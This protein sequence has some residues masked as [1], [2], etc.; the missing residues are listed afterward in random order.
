MVQMLPCLVSELYFSKVCYN[1]NSLILS[2]PSVSQ[3]SLYYFMSLVHK[4]LSSLVYTLNAFKSE[5]KFFTSPGAQHC[6]E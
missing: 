1:G 2:L 5:I 4:S 6:I 3:C